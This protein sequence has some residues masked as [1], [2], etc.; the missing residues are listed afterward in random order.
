MI[1][2]SQV[3]FFLPDWGK[4]KPKQT[5]RHNKKKKNQSKQLGP[6]HLLMAPVGRCKHINDDKM[7]DIRLIQVVAK[8]LTFFLKKNKKN[9]VSK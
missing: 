1:V 6:A 2:S 3:D 7:N 4:G 8:E 9:Q 5:R